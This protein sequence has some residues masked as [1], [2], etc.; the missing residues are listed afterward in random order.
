MKQ[1]DYRSGSVLSW[2]FSFF[3]T[4]SLIILSKSLTG[5]KSSATSWKTC[6]HRKEQGLLVSLSAGSASHSL[7]L[8]LYRHWLSKYAHFPRCF[9]GQT[10]LW[11]SKSWFWLILHLTILP[12]WSSCRQEVLRGQTLREAACQLN[13]QQFIGRGL[14]ML[15]SVQLSAEAEGY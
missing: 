9:T 5:R 7:L 11:L 3:F 14:N 13:K 15:P 2:E 1:S 8:C 10:P 6:I 12:L 4:T